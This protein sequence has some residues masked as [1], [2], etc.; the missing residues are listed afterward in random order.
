MAVRLISLKSWS[1]RNL[2]KTLEG[3]LVPPFFFATV[4]AH[5]LHRFATISPDNSAENISHAYA[6]LT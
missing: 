3:G 1:L 5:P 4:L 2:W 6:M